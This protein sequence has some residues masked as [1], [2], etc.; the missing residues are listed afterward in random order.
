M[1]YQQSWLVE[2]YKL[3]V[4]RV[5][6]NLIGLLVNSLVKLTDVNINRQYIVCA[7]PEN[8]TSPYK[9][10]IEINSLHTSRNVKDS[11]R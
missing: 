5:L 9:S 3:F 7:F 10:F 11:R 4:D 2:E 8:S 6:L 1:M